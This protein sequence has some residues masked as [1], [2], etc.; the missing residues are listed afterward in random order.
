VDD[1]IARLENSLDELTNKLRVV[2][3]PR[4]G[5]KDDTILTPPDSD[6]SPLVR[7]LSEQA[8]RL[9]DRRALVEAVI[10]ALEI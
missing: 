7:Q 5:T 6:A 2:L 9:R 4:F 10:A 3:P 1:A 8:E